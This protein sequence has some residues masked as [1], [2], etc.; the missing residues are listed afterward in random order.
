MAMGAKTT[1]AGDWTV[2]PLH[3]ARTAIAVVV[4]AA[5]TTKTTTAFHANVDADL[6]LA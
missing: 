6:E 2:Q 4:P 5:T 1:Q 3:A